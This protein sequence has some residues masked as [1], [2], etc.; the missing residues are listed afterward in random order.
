MKVNVATLC[1]HHLCFWCVFVKNI[2][3]SETFI[4]G[5]NNQCDEYETKQQPEESEKDPNDSDETDERTT[6][7]ILR[8][9]ELPLALLDG[10][11]TFQEAIKEYI[12]PRPETEEDTLKI[13]KRLE[14]R[15]DPPQNV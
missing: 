4:P 2:A 13:V 3:F 5:I 14:A 8:N 7:E 6:L 11:F 15:L 1:R 12:L 10:L 9:I